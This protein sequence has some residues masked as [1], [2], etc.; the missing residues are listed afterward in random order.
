MLQGEDDCQDDPEDGESTNENEV[1]SFPTANQD[2]GIK[3]NLTCTN[4]GTMSGAFKRNHFSSSVSQVPKCLVSVNNIPSSCEKGICKALDPYTHLCQHLFS[5]CKPKMEM[6]TSPT[7]VPTAKPDTKPEA[8]STN[9]TEGEDTCLRPC[10]LS[11]YLED[12]PQDMRNVSRIFT[13]RKK[14]ELFRFKSQI[15]CCFSS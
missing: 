10:D 7:E 5:P 15:Q 11:Y 3:C 6:E 1:V 8:S 2:E 9:S 14:I 4:V 13:D 12:L